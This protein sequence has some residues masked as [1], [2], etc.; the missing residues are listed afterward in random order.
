M[1]TGFRWLRPC[2][3]RLVLAV[4]KYLQYAITALTLV[5]SRRLQHQ[6]RPLHSAC[7]QLAEPTVRQ[8]DEVP[9]IG[10]LPVRKVMAV[11][12]DKARRA[13]L[14]LPQRAD[15]NGRSGH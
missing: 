6:I 8:R 10:H 1:T 2:V 7:I 9:E 14:P 15:A 11:G 4:V 3:L 12:S 13:V 5:G